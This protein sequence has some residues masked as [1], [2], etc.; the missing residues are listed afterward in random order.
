MRAASRARATAAAAGAD[1]T[2]L[3]ALLDAGFT[4]IR[5]RRA[6]GVGEVD[7]NLYLDG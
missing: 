1:I 5:Q 6:N 3:E 2:W 7:D 4:L